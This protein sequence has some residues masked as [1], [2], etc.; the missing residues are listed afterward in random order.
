[1]VCNTLRTDPVVRIDR[2]DRF[3]RCCAA[4]II[5]HNTPSHSSPPDGCDVGRKRI[6][7]A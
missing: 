4:F 2:G 3:D 5:F 7:A 1:M 6:E